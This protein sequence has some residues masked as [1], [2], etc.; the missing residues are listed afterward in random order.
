[1]YSYSLL[2]SQKSPTQSMEYNR[3][4]GENDHD[5]N[6]LFVDSWSKI[7]SQFLQYY[8]II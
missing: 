6:K 3:F 4:E 7:K 8:Q 2:L 5:H 1:M